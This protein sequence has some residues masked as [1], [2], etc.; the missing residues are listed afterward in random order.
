VRHDV[1][2]AEPVAPQSVPAAT[3]VGANPRRKLATGPPARPLDSIAAGDQFRDGQ[4]VDI[5]DQVQRRADC[6]AVS[7]RD[8]TSP[9]QQCYRQ[10]NCRDRPYVMVTPPSTA[11]VCPVT[12][13]AA[14][15]ASQTSVAASSSG[16]PMRCNTIR[17]LIRS[18]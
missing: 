1:A 9:A 5:A 15:D 2:D 17:P 6:L 3:P 12:Y 11:M 14:S 7:V 8:W 10:V 18:A 13:P 4:A 16:S